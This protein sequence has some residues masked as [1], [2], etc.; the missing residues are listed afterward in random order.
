M[1]QLTHLSFARMAMKSGKYGD[2]IRHL[3][4]AREFSSSPLHHVEQ[5]LI[6]IEVSSLPLLPEQTGQELNKPGCTHV[7][8][9]CAARGRG[10]QG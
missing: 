6:S 4:S 7:Q 10:V 3:G 2:V 8:P 5:G 9:S 1:A